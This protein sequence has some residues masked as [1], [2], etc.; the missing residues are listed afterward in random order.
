MNAVSRVAVSLIAVGSIAVLWQL[1][2]WRSVSWQLVS[3]QSVRWWMLYF[4][5]SVV[6][7]VIS[8]TVLIHCTLATSTLEDTVFWR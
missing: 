7:A 1:V 6:N 3:W 8:V 5:G 4:G 2:R